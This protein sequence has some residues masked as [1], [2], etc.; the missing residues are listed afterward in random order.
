MNSSEKLSAKQSNLIAL[1]LTERTIDEACKKAKVS[2]STYWRWMQDQDFLDQYGS[3]RHGILENT[4]AKLQSL[5]FQ[6]IETHERNLNCENPSVEI[7]CA[8]IILEQSVKGIEVLGLQNRVE[9]LE[10][11]LKSI[12]EHNAQVSEP[13]R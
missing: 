5:S 2:V 6:A 1:L 9:Y 4:V 3:A 8:T 10:S 7:R 12:E 11:V 13:S